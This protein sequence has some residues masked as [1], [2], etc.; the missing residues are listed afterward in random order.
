MIKIFIK[1]FSSKNLQTILKNTNPVN[2]FLKFKRKHAVLGNLGVNL[3]GKYKKIFY[4]STR[5][6]MRYS[7]GSS[8]IS[9]S[10]PPLL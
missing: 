10:P 3:P 4:V 7:Y 2:L 8:K 1:N 5:G 9:T 6:L